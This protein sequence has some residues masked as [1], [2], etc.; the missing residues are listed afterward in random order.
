MIPNCVPSLA[1]RERDYLLQ[2]LDGTHLATGPFI[3]RFED[4]IRDYVGAA[5]AVAVN[6]GTAALHLALL[7]A[8][9][10]AEDEVLVPAFTFA[11]TANAVRYC[12]ARPL[13]T[14][15]ED[16]SWGMD[17]R[18]IEEFLS[19]DCDRQGEVLINRASGRRVSAM[20]PVHLYGHPADLDPLVQIA[21]RYGLV[22]VEDGAEALGATY[23][24]R[25]V[26]SLH[27]TCILSF[28]GNKII[29]AGGGG[30]VLTADEA[31]AK[32]CRYLANQAKADSLDFVHETIGF[33]YRMPNLNAAL[34]LGQAEKLDEF[35]AAKRAIARGY[36]E[37]LDNL[38]GC[39]M[40]RSSEQVENAH[41]MAVLELDGGDAAT[42]ID[43]LVERGI[44]AR[45]TWRPLNQQRAFA[46][47]A[48]LPTPVTDNIY[49]STVCLPCSSGI[50]G[51]ELDRVADTVREV[52]GGKERQ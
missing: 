38:P 4:Y 26:G 48:S 45:P 39:R 46:D 3:G 37:R 25:R 33:N 36:G 42:I 2:A 12:G 43:G 47:A 35:L 22:V 21:E 11:A 23:K 13:F 40:R 50:T 19:S 49:R 52:L 15:C 14:D 29:T 17:P 7:A 31:V 8:G 20:V 24:G 32:R 10:E 41:W 1:G 44:G 5:H 16:T 30:M 27:Q 18:L 6:S 51:G 9:V 34:A 28:N